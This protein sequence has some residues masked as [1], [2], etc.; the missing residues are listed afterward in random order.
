MG[1]CL[2]IFDANGNNT[3]SISYGWDSEINDWVRD[4]V[5]FI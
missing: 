2:Y 1:M 3:E 4:S 5:M